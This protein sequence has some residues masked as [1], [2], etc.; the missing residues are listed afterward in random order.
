MERPEESQRQRAFLVDALG[1]HRHE[2]LLPP[3]L[4]QDRVRVPGRALDQAQDQF[5]HPRAHLALLALLQE[6]KQET[7]GGGVDN[8]R[9]PRGGRSG[10]GLEQGSLGQLNGSGGSAA[11]HGGEETTGRVF[12]RGLCR[13]DGYPAKGGR[14]RRRFRALPCD[15]RGDR[16]DRLAPEHELEQRRPYVVCQWESNERLSHRGHEPRGRH[17]VFTVPGV[18]RVGGVNF[19]GPRHQRGEQANGDRPGL[20][21]RAG[22]GREDHRGAAAL[23]DDGPG[24]PRPERRPGLE[25]VDE[26]L[27]N[28]GGGGA[29][30]V[31]FTGVLDGGERR[32]NRLVVHRGNGAHE[33]LAHHGEQ[34]PATG[35]RRRR[36]QPGV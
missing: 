7:R 35:A 17:L 23:A 30:G 34:R 3:G 2:P 22:E 21:V 1:E 10:D 4:A 29:G 25:H 9:Y 6:S 13:C 27:Q 14:F 18:V 12:S 5:Q 16:G 32:L 15:W 19:P 8:A 26:S 33:E 36:V 20:R 31:R 28:V 24:E 11:G